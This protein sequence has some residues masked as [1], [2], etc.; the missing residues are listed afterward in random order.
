[1]TSDADP[2]VALLPLIDS[3]IRQISPLD[4]VSHDLALTHATRRWRLMRQRRQIVRATTTPTVAMATP[5]SVTPK[6]IRSKPAKSIARLLAAQEAQLEQLA[7][8]NAAR[9]SERIVQL[10]AAAA[11]TDTDA[12]VHLDQVASLK[13]EIE[14]QQRR[15]AHLRKA[16]AEERRRVAAGGAMLLD[17][18]DAAAGTTDLIVEQALECAVN[19]FPAIFDEVP[20][21]RKMQ[22]ARSAL[23]A[24]IAADPNAN[25]V[26]TRRAIVTDRDCWLAR[27]QSSREVSI[28]QLLVELGDASVPAAATVAAADESSLESGEIVMSVTEIAR[29]RSIRESHNELVEEE[30]VVIEENDGAALAARSSLREAVPTLPI[31]DNYVAPPPP[32]TPKNGYVLR[33]AAKWFPFERRSFASFD[34]ACHWV[35]KLMG[36]RKLPAHQFPTKD[37]FTTA[38]GH[39]A[40]AGMDHWYRRFNTL[41]TEACAPNPIDAQIFISL[42]ATASPNSAVAQNALNALL[43]FRALSQGLRPRHGT[44]PLSSL[45]NFLSGVLGRPS[46]A[47]V[48]CF[49]DNLVA[50][51][52]SQRVT[53]DTHMIAFLFGNGRQ[54]LAPWEY[55]L[56]EEFYRSAAHECAPG[57]LPHRFQSAVWHSRAGEANFTDVLLSHVT[58]V[59]FRIA[60][61]P[62]LLA[63]ALE[64]RAPARV[65]RKLDFDDADEAPR[66][67]QAESLVSTA[68]DFV[69]ALLASG[70][71]TRID[72]L[73]AV[74]VRRVRE[75]LLGLGYLSLPASDEADDGDV[76]QI[77]LRLFAPV[78]F[79]NAVQLRATLASRRSMA[80]R[81]GRELF[82]EEQREA[83]RLIARMS[84]IGPN[85]S[86]AHPDDQEWLRRDMALVDAALLSGTTTLADALANHDV[87]AVQDHDPYTRAHLH[88]AA[89]ESHLRAVL[90][91]DEPGAILCDIWRNCAA[92]I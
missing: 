88:F 24:I 8:T 19:R 11:A 85:E 53:V 40:A 13:R 64:H 58:V 83:E 41:I 9:I 18:D 80:R 12:D 33:R 68:A 84:K 22:I 20:S 42:L 90:R 62:A 59:S 26:V 38:F 23:R 91:A 70:D 52:T 63:A 66:E 92:M 56:L 34:V 77:S 28:E 3:A 76:A 61:T 45:V 57:I 51:D 79:E 16:H 6:L 86:V 46:G 71:A 2:R 47:K 87:A 31:L 89:H 72:V 37:A 10:G 82:A 1:M 35:A 14:V 81:Q 29:L 50:C 44:Y 32:P 36:W 55:A 30:E 21:N 67:L 17:D 75:L 54:S 78:R 39:G 5:T 43:N 7:Q 74:A 69:N 25:G 4:P 60:P 73:R 27:D 49:L 65:K 48:Q 15:F